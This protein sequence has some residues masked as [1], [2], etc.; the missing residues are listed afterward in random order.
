MISLDMS[1]IKV[2]RL[3]FELTSTEQT[4][5][6]LKQMSE[7]VLT[8]PPFDYARTKTGLPRSIRSSTQGRPF[9][10]YVSTFGSLRSNVVYFVVLWFLK[11]S[12][13]SRG[14][15]DWGYYDL[16]VKEPEYVNV[17]APECPSFL[18]AP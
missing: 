15:T 8:A 9:L 7:R 16:N 11:E 3:Y 1:R 14:P 10:I 12:L 5:S 6:P 4:P 13:M 17:V 18:F 2:I